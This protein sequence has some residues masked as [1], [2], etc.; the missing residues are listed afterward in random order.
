MA[1]IVLEIVNC[2]QCPHFKTANQWSSDGWDK[3]EDWVCDKNNK[4]IQES[5]EW[6]EESKIDVPDWCPIK[7]NEENK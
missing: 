2:R 3:M 5:V 1:Q 7:L 4:I 6:H